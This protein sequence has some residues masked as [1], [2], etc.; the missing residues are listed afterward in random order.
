MSLPV[1][2]WLALVGSLCEFLAQRQVELMIMQQKRKKLFVDA[3]VQGGLAKRITLH[4]FVFFGIVVALQF[5][6]AWMLNPVQSFSELSHSII[7]NNGLFLI[8]VAL[9]LPA[10][11]LD[12]VKVSNKFA[13]PIVRLKNEFNEVSKTGELK[14]IGFR[15]GD[16][17]TELADAYNGLVHAVNRKH[18]KA[19]G[20]AAS[21]EAAGNSVADQADAESQWSEATS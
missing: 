12:S 1:V 15:E 19:S 8:A 10:F 17:W 6:T 14:E 4:W 9:L 16:Y 13:G 18:E 3:A 2:K 20:E 21:H 7:Q 11:V 5:L